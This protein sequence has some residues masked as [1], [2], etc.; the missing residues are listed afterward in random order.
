MRAWI[1]VLPGI[2][3][4]ILLWSG[5]A[6]AQAKPADCPKP[7]APEKVAGPVVKVDMQQAKLTLRGSDGTTHEFEASKQTLQD[8]KVRDRIELK[9][10]MAANCK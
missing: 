9:L 5:L 3:A 6:L 8:V 2:S 1:R 4:T 7:G 10:R